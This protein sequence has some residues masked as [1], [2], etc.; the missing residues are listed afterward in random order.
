MTIETLRPNAAGDETALL[1]S[2]GTYNW[3][4]VDEAVADDAATTVHAYA[5][6]YKRDLYNLPS[7]SVGSGTINSVKIYFRIYTNSEDYDCFGKPVQKSGTTV[8]EGTEQTQPLGSW[9]TKSQ[10][11]TLNPATAAAYTW[12]EIDALQVGVA[13]TDK[14]Y[15]HA[16]YSTQVYIDVDYTAV[17]TWELVST[18][19]LKLTDVEQAV[20]SKILSDGL[21]LAD[22]LARAA[23]KTLTDGL[24]IT[25]SWAGYKLLV[26]VLTDGLAYADA[27]VK[28]TIKTLSD[29]L[30]VTDTLAKATYKT[31]SDGLLVTD[32]LARLTARTLADGLA[33]TDNLVRTFARTFTDGLAVTDAWGM[34]WQHGVMRI[35]NAVRNQLAVRNQGK[36]R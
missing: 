2:G 26:Q 1:K 5:A 23:A 17:T 35:V 18:D 34:V 32:T 3:E 31:I 14:A 4:M 20:T 10:T 11:Y 21:K 29:G 25:D 28:S 22:T 16:A 30:L 12:A 6:T 15:S 9:G 36:A 7:H 27:L 13:L 8:T 24:A 19:G 33:F